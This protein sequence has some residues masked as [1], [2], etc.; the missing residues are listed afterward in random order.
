MRVGA[1]D[2]PIRAL[3]ERSNPR[4]RSRLIWPQLRPN[5]VLRG[6]F[7]AAEINQFTTEWGDDATRMA[8]GVA[9]ER[10]ILVEHTRKFEAYGDVISIRPEDIVGWRGRLPSTPTRAHIITGVVHCAL[11]IVFERKTLYAIRC[12]R[13]AGVPCGE[14]TIVLPDFLAADPARRVWASS[15]GH[16][17][18]SNLGSRGRA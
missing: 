4:F 8:V 10:L 16:A 17:R 5:E 6:S 1:V 14:F 11:R 9:N 15:S 3:L 13:Y 12:Y 18:R 7:L 2:A